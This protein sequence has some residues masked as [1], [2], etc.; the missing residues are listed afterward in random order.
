MPRSS[1][2]PL[3]PL[4]ALFK[5]AWLSSKTASRHGQETHRIQWHIVMR[6]MDANP[7][8]FGG[9]TKASV[10]YVELGRMDHSKLAWEDAGLKT[11]DSR[12]MNLWAQLF[13]NFDRNWT[14]P[15]FLR[16][17]HAYWPGLGDW[18]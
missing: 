15:E 7:G 10:L 4:G 8:A 3:A 12:E 18:H 2:Q 13:D 17:Y 9:V 5:D 1:A 14:S 11:K 6:A 16:P